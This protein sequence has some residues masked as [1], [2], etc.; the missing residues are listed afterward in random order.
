MPQALPCLSHKAI[1]LTN[2]HDTSPLQNANANGKSDHIRYDS[3]V[4]RIRASGD[5]VEDEVAESDEI[6]YGTFDELY[7]VSVVAS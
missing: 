4:N 1:T 6:E 3:I 2:A 7:P 5:S